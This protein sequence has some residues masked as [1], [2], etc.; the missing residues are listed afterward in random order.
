[1]KCKYD[2]F[3]EWVPKSSE[4]PK[5]LYLKSPKDERLWVQIDVTIGG[6]RSCGCKTCAAHPDTDWGDTNKFFELLADAGLDMKVVP[7]K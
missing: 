1:M 3:W 6:S 4:N 7:P 5:T 2:K